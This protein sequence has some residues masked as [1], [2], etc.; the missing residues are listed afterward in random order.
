MLSVKSTYPVTTPVH[1]T[2]SCN[3]AISALLDPEHK[4]IQTGNL[5]AE[6]AEGRGG[7]ISG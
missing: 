2:L 4:M 6:Y 5:T 1:K 3:F 7:E